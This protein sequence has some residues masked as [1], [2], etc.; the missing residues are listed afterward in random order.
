MKTTSTCRL[1]L[2]YLLYSPKQANSVDKV[3]IVDVDA[4]GSQN[5]HFVAMP[6][7]RGK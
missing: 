5:A 7:R 4:S 3:D 6:V 2:Q 1:H